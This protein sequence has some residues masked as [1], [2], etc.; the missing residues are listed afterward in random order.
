VSTKIIPK[1]KLSYEEFLSWCDEDTFAEWID[2]KVLMFSPA[3]IQHQD[4]THWLSTILRIYVENKNLGKIITAPFQMY[5]KELKRGREPDIIFILNENINRLNTVYL[6]GP[7]DLVVEIVS[8]ETK[9]RDKEEKL[10]E[11]EKAKV[12]EYWI[13]D[14]IDKNA[15]FYVLK[16]NTFIKNEPIKGIYY[17]KVIYSLWL[18]LD[19]LFKEPLP[20]VLDVIK[21]LIERT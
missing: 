3:S 18:K 10:K 9:K 19:W 15:E 2:G 1:T 13:I 4:I 8:T 16:D 14:P 5:L 17:S 7:A 11:Y 20:N 6:S 12:K 21:N